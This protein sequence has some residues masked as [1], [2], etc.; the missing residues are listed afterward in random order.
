MK[1]NKIF[2]INYIEPIIKI[3]TI[4]KNIR[5][6]GF[7]AKSKGYIFEKSIINAKKYAL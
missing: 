6:C 5:N 2:K 4:T 3:Q 7:H 1:N